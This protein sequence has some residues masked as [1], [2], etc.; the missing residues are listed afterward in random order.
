MVNRPAFREP[1]IDAVV[2]GV[3]APVPDVNVK[4]PPGLMMSYFDTTKTFTQQL[5]IVSVF[6][7]FILLPVIAEPQ[8]LTPK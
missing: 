4:E 8:N 5:S 3:I 1:P 2:P 6:E 7:A